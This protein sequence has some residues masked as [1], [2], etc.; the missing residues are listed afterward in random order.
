MEVR[1]RLK[2]EAASPGWEMAGLTSKGTYKG[3]SWV[4]ARQSDLPTHPSES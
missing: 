3:L 1:E 4:A 2:E